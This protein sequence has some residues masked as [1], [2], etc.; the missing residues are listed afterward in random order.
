MKKTVIVFITLILICVTLS[1]EK[2]SSSDLSR[3][4][5]V[6]M[7]ILG[8]EP[9]LDKEVMD[10]LNKILAEKL[11]T[12]LKVRY[13]SWADFG[14]GMYPMLFTSGDVFD[15][16]Y[17]AT[18]LNW[19]QL[20]RRGA[21]KDIS[22]LFPEYAPKNYAR[23]S[24]TALFQA[25][26]DG[27]LYAIPSL[28][29]TYSAFGA[30]YR[31]DLAVKNGWDGK[32]DSIRDIERY[33]A[34]VKE[35]HPEIEPFDVYNEGSFMDDMWMYNQ[36]F[37]SLKGATNDFL[38]IYPF[39]E[40]PQIFTYY[41]FNRI[42]EFLS[43]MDRWNKAGY[44]SKSALS[45]SD[46]EKLANG[47]TAMR[48]H[49]VDTYE[50]VYRNTPKEWGIRWFNL[51][52]DISNMSFTQDA[53]AISNTSR[54]PERALML[55]DLITND[56]EVFRAF[57]Y[58]IEGKTYRIFEED[59]KKYVEQLDPV[60]FSFS[61]NWAARTNEF[62]FPTHGAPDDVDTYRASYDAYIQDGIGSQKFRSFVID[63]SS[64]E[65][66]Y[67]ACENAHRTYWFPLELGFVNI[68]TGLREYENRMK[69]AGI[70]K[71]KQVLQAQLDS[72]LKEISGIY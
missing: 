31:S 48:M 25:T 3:R 26:V 36:G 33:F 29:S 16:V 59:G 19:T 64:I 43:M 69:A 67:A 49:N 52:K 65:T 63:I 56:E 1:C 71:V 9:P 11:N 55:W 28:L 5:E 34:V 62:S 10:N 38:F 66:E 14:S 13:L 50:G 18:W 32:M 44:F 45:D 20:A 51:V 40:N 68:N 27:K 17:T 72:Y 8:D 22:G 42:N 57:Y 2:G 60:G 41:E 4:I 24:Q 37:Y 35:N 70:D 39:D 47:R 58:G 12:T 54:N 7:W 21:F 46:S 15:L 53:V 30:I 6:V 61:S 23:Q